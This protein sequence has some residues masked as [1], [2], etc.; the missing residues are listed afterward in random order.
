MKYINMIMIFL[1]YKVFII[2]EI[3]VALIS[4]NWSKAAENN[5]M[6]TLIWPLLAVPLPEWVIWEVWI[7]SPDSYP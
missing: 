2:L 6:I 7:T 1:F 4:H 3:K 5:G